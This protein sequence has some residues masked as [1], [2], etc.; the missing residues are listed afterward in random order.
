MNQETHVTS[1]QW[2]FTVIIEPDP[3]DGG[4]IVHCPALKGCWSQGEAVEEALHNI[5]DAISGWLAVHIERSL[6]IPHLSAS[7]RLTQPLT[8]SVQIP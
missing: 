3:D 4:Y 6:D 2:A 1:D 8:L 7:E 5:V